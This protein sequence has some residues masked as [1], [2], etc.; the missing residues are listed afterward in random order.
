[1]LPKSQKLNTQNNKV[2]KVEDVTLCYSYVVGKERELDT[3]FDI[4]FNKI[5]QN[6]N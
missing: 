3:A 2:Q 6:K 1:M 5:L 4:L